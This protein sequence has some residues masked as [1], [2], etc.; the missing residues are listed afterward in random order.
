MISTST[1]SEVKSISSVFLIFARDVLVGVVA[2]LAA[3]WLDYR[4][5]RG[6]TWIALVLSIAGLAWAFLSGTRWISLF[7]ASL[8]PSAFALIAMVMFTARYLEKYNRDPESML[9]WRRL[10]F[11]L[12]G[13]VLVMAF[14]ITSYIH[15]YVLRSVADRALP[16]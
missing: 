10:I 6:I 9:S 16:G 2:M 13:P 14:L 12:W 8:Q 7:G 15:V 11:D 3:C 4:C 5:Y 1:I